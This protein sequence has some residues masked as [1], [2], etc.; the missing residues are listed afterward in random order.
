MGGLLSLLGW[1]ALG[2]GVVVLFR[3]L[4]QLGLTTR[5][6]AVALIV[7]GLLVVGVGSRIPGSAAQNPNAGDS[8]QATAQ[9]PT[10]A[11]APTP[12][13]KPTSTPTPTPTPTAATPP[14]T[15]KPVVVVATAK[16]AAP[17]PPPP[18]PA[19]NYCGAPSN[20]WH[21]NFCG[22]S[23]V[24]NPP[25]PTFCNYFGCIA[26]FWT[27][28]I[29]ND[30]YVIQCVDGTYSLSGGES[31]SCSHHGGNSRPLNAP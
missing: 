9:A 23:L 21:Y 15:Q 13:A 22:G 19:F 16:P 1:V 27:E 11:P 20:P 6:H 25:N 12:T 24:S 18:P 26:S 8:S 14:P 17:P 30:G 7:G 2:L 3:R 31:G 4:P 29:P 10:T 28:D 5:G